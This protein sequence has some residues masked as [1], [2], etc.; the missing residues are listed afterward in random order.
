MLDE[1]ASSGMDYIST[2]TA[3]STRFLV[4][5]SE[6]FLVTL[7]LTIATDDLV[8]LH[9]LPYSMSGRNGASRKIEVGFSVWP[10]YLKPFPLFEGMTNGIPRARSNHIR[11]LTRHGEHDV[12]HLDD[13]EV[14]LQ[15]RHRR[16]DLH[17]RGFHALDSR[18]RRIVP[19][20]NV[21]LGMEILVVGD[22]E[23]NRSIRPYTASMMEFHE[24]V[25]EH[26]ALEQVKE[27]YR[28]LVGWSML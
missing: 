26:V 3:E 14:S 4:W 22:R 20:M 23:V 18:L 16:I 17:S 24:W 13:A 10:D 2:T 9:L 12:R 8:T 25:N 7:T 21:N 27:L 5:L 19:R 1:S 6:V 11:E 28:L 15:I